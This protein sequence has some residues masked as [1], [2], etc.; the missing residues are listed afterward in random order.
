[1]RQRGMTLVETMVAAGLGALV[2]AYVMSMFISSLANFAGL[3]NYAMLTGQ[4]RMTL[5]SLSRDFRE[6]TQI[7]SYTNTATAKSLTLTNSFEG[8][9]S[10]YSWDST[11]KALTCTKTGQPV[12]TYLTGCDAWDFSFYQRTPN[13]NWTFFTTTDLTLCKLINM[14]WK[15]SRLVVGTMRNTENVVTAQIVLRNKP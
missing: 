7:L 9:S 13:N 14:S 4:S 10:T 11:S 12:K 6:A 3:G 1:M 15:C 5:D 8:W 2:L